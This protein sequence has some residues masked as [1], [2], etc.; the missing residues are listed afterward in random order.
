M[1]TDPA[2][3]D[4]LRLA[5]EN[6]LRSLPGNFETVADTAQLMSEIF[7]YGLPVNY[8]QSCRGSMSK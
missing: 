5:K 6:A 1:Q 2:T 7:I 8:Y 4:E 3:E